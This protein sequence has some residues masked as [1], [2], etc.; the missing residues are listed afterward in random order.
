MRLADQSAG[1]R[2]KEVPDAAAVGCC[3]SSDELFRAPL[4][5]QFF[6]AGNLME[7]NGIRLSFKSQK[8]SNKLD[9]ASLASFKRD[10][11]NKFSK[12]KS[13]RK[14]EKKC[15]SSVTSAL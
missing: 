3:L 11:N 4:H 6:C 12:K 1:T 9:C 2:L 14:N 8:K 15:R 5:L 7:L 13:V 10:N